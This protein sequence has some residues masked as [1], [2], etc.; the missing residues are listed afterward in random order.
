MELEIIWSRFAENQLDLIFEY[1]LDKAN[2][3]VAIELVQNLINEPERLKRD[4]FIGQEED[5]LKNRK[6]SYRYL[7]FKN[8][9]IIYSVD[10]ENGFIKVADVFDTRQNPVT[11]KRTK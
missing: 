8:Y 7:I 3:K 4:P 9:K 11:L 5:L 6:I 1:Y 2:E 10:L